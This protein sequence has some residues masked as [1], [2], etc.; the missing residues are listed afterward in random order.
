MN[1]IGS[2]PSSA[3]IQLYLP[4]LEF[5]YKGFYPTYRDYNFNLLV[6]DLN[7]Y[8]IKIHEELYNTVVHANE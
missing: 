5:V 8:I 2:S 1:L 3:I 4:R 7:E 6:T